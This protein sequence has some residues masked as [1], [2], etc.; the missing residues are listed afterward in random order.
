ML[1]SN[2][3]LF[4]VIICTFDYKH[5]LGPR[6]VKAYCFTGKIWFTKQQKPLEC[7]NKANPLPRESVNIRIY[8][9]GIIHMRSS[10]EIHWITSFAHP[11]KAYWLHWDIPFIVSK[12]MQKFSI[13]NGSRWFLILK[14]HWVT[15][16]HLAL[17][18]LFCLQLLLYIIFLYF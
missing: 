17:L 3:S 13:T 15:V 18:C 9:T 6:M 1:I 5:N 14:G 16:S 12:Q 4:L 8:L 11:E 2:Q 10:F 7:R